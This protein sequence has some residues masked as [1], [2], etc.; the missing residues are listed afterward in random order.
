MINDQNKQKR[1]ADGEFER[2]DQP[3]AQE[4]NGTIMAFFTESWK[5]N[6]FNKQNFYWCS[7][8]WVCFSNS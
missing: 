1:P 7:S 5:V 6:S 3:D 8:Q 4:S 2:Q